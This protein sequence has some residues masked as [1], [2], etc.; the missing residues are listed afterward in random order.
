MTVCCCW[1]F[2]RAQPMFWCQAADELRGSGSTVPY[3][4]NLQ[5]AKEGRSMKKL[6]LCLLSLS[7][8]ALSLS[9]FAQIQN[10]QFTGTVSDPSGASVANARVTVTNVAT[11][12]SVAT[13]T[14]QEGLYVARE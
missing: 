6:Q 13:T 1:S 4:D 14:N 2:H 8:L 5:S 11:N 9:A 7:L 10:G 12:L 3:K